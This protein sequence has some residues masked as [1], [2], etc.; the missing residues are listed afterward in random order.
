MEDLKIIDQLHATWLQ[1]D[2]ATRLGYLV[3][4]KMQLNRM[5]DQVAVA[6]KNRG[7]NMSPEEKAQARQLLEMIDAVNQEGIR[8]ERDILNEGVKEFLKTMITR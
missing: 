2:N 5:A 8:T 7:G 1:M 3:G 6:V 4:Q